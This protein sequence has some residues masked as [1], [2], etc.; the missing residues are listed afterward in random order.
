[1]VYWSQFLTTDTGPGFVSRHYQI[2]R[3]AVGLERDPPSLVTI[4]EE[5]LERKGTGSDLEN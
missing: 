1:M 2:F 5:L 4:T 3:V